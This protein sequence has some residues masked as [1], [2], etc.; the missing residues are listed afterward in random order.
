MCMQYVH[1]PD[2]RLHVLDD[3]VLNRLEQM[4]NASIT[5]DNQSKSVSVTHSDSVA[6]MEATEVI[7]AVAQGFAPHDAMQLLTNQD[8]RFETI[9]IKNKTRNEKE[10]RR[11]KGRVIGENGRTRE[12]LEELGGA[13]VC[14]YQDAVSII[15]EPLEVQTVRRA[16]NRLISGE[17][18]ASVYGFLEERCSQMNSPLMDFGINPKQFG[19]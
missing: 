10:F 16:V 9:N 3:A 5:I 12:L 8:V 6:E 11:Q 13:S 7:R 18:H 4:T 15:G 2:E 19:N 17:S 14:I 1:V